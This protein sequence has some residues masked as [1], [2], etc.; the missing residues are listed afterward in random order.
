M[1]ESIKSRLDDSVRM[2][3]CLYFHC[4]TTFD[5]VKEC[6]LILKKGSMVSDV[7]CIDVDI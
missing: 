2:E 5:I 7:M 6:H 1:R 3:V 4:A